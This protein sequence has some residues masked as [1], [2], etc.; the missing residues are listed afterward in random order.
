MEH[1][2][3]EQ[4]NMLIEGLGRYSPAI[5]LVKYNVFVDMAEN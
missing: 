2:V 5:D 3:Y 4:N 1:N